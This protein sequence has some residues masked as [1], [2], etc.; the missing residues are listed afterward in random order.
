LFLVF[1][2]WPIFYFILTEYNVISHNSV[3]LHSG[4]S[5]YQCGCK[6]HTF[7]ALLYVL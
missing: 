3:M 5:M 2:Y 7:G 4:G 6:F 1:L